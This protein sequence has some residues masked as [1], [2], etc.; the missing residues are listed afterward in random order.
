MY[1]LVDLIR[2]RD[3]GSGARTVI[4]HNGVSASYSDL[5]SGARACATRLRDHGVR[6]GDRVLLLAPR[7]VSAAQAFFGIVQA[8][9]VAVP[10]PDT[11]KQAQV[12]QMAGD[13]GAVAAIAGRRAVP[14]LPPGLPVLPVDTICTPGASGDGLPGVMPGDLAALLYTSGSTGTP[15]GVMVTHANLLAGAESVVDYLGLTADDRILSVLPWSFDYGLNQLTGAVWAGATVV[16]GQAA[17]VPA[18]CRTLLASR[19][20]VL[21]AVPPLWSML[22]DERSPFLELDLPDLRLVTNSGGQLPAH[23]ITAVRTRHRHVRLFSMYGLTEAFRSTYL[24]PDLID[25]HPDSIG[26]AIPGAECLVLDDDDRECSP[27]EVGQLVH[28]GPTVAAGY[29]NRPADTARVFR[30]LPCSPPGAV[31]ETV[32]YSGDYVRRGAAGLLYFVGR[33]DQ[34]FK[35]RGVRVNPSQVE[36]ALMMAGIAKQAVVF[37]V[38]HPRRGD[39]DIF[40]VIIAAAGV[41]SGEVVARCVRELPSQWVPTRVL[42]RADLPR[43]DNGKVDRTAVRAAVLASLAP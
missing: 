22:V 43:T 16:V 7:G 31:A 20:T 33:R 10:V 9:A 40:A 3:A 32:V 17:L 4:E 39:T 25:T 11:A 21:A 2:S 36:D 34:Q 26:R 15:K 23:V 28:R 18:L 24:D 1:S 41:E 12:G 14:V 35:S 13:C 27:G 42:L 19:A 29:W 37:G 6:R 5:A 8:G 30:P 38:P